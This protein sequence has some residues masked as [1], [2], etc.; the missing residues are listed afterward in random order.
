MDKKVAQLTIL[1]EQYQSHIFHN[2]IKTS[3][4]AVTSRFTTCNV[5]SISGSTNDVGATSRCS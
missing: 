5:L 2:I 4:Q 3:S 1:S